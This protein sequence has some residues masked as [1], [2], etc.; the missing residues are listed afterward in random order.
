MSGE[1]KD[2][3]LAN[4]PPSRGPEPKRPEPEYTWPKPVIEGP[5]KYDFHEAEARELSFRKPPEDDGRGFGKFLDEK[6]QTG[7]PVPLKDFQDARDAVRYLLL[8][9]S[10]HVTDLLKVDAIVADRLVQAVDDKEGRLVSYLPERALKARLS[11]PLDSVAVVTIEPYTVRHRYERDGVAFHRDDRWMTVGW[12]LWS[13]AQAYQRIYDDW[14]KWGIWGH[15]I[16]DL[17]FEQVV[18]KDDEAWIGVGS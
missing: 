15:S 17:V 13:L 12:Y 18:I 1:E 16:R 9:T 6:M 2:Y 11:Y 10:T 4:W 7:E 14:K 5:L 8:S 3:P